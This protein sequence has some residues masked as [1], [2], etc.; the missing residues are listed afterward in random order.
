MAGKTLPSLPNLAER[1][2]GLSPSKVEEDE[3]ELIEETAPVHS[4]AS[5]YA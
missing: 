2:G 1:I 3:P 5:A 4:A